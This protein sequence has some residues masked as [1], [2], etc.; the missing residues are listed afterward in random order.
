[1]CSSASLLKSSLFIEERQ[2]L[3]YLSL[4]AHPP[5][6]RLTN[7]AAVEVVAVEIHKGGKMNRRGGSVGKA[8]HSLLTT[9]KKASFLRDSFSSSSSP[10]SWLEAVWGSALAEQREEVRAAPGVR[11]MKRAKPRQEPHLR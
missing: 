10:A 11:G 6:C 3:S 7:K 1:M 8:R 2:H 5:A 9:H 4:P